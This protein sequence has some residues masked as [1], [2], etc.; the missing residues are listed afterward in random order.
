MEESLTRI[1][2]RF[3]EK[4]LT[5]RPWREIE[6]EFKRTRDQRRRVTLPTLVCLEQEVEDEPA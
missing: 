4:V 5:G 6:R 2:A 1:L 3:R